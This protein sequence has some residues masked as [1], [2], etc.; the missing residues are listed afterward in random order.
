[1]SPFKTHVYLTDETV[2]AGNK[3]IKTKQNNNNSNKQT[4]Q[5]QQQNTPVT[6]K[7][8]LNLE[9]FLCLCDGMW[10]TT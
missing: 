1:M 4:K 2:E 5:K 9:L 8:I 7:S 6:G 10:K 3:S